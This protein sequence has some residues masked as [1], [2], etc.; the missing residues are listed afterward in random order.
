M[1]RDLFPRF[2][3]ELFFF[4]LRLCNVKICAQCVAD[5]VAGGCVVVAGSC[6]DRRAQVGVE[7][8][9]KHIGCCAAERGAAGSTLEF[10]QVM[11]SFGFVGHGLDLIVADDSAVGCDGQC[12]QTK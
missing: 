9:W 2:R 11:A 3:V 8:D 10:G 4:R 7:A 12:L 5:D 6:F 1:I